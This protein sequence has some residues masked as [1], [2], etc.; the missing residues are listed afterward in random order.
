MN[1]VTCTKLDNLQTRL[2]RE[3]GPLDA[4]AL[5]SELTMDLVVKTMFSSEL[6]RDITPISDAISLLQQDVSERMW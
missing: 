6:N 3:G 2:Q 1:Q 5:M 4:L